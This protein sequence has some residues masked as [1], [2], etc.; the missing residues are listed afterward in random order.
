MTVTE[1]KAV[2]KQKFQIEIDGQPAFVLYKGELS[3]YH[4]RK[5]ENITEEVYREIT[6]QVLTKRAKIRAMHL[7]EKMDRT[8]AD[9]RKKLQ[10]SGYPP[11][12]VEAAI[13]YVESFHYID[14]S[15]YAAAYIENQKHKKGR[16]RLK[17][18]LLQKGVA[19]EDIERAFA[20]T[21]ESMD[22][23][24]AIR[25]ML[26]RK[27]H[28]GGPMDEKEKQRLYGYFMRKG[29]TSSDILSVFREYAE[30]NTGQYE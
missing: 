5:E 27:R 17:M 20:Q 21:E 7:L 22:P 25:E 3:R 15:R 29:F 13:R 2:T 10:Q 14:D 16:A 1:I 6:E 24:A 8:E 30:L 9:L 12:A 23:R 4:I 26:E 28:G 19:S 18:E 11:S